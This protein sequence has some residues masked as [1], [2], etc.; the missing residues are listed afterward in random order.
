[1]IDSGRVEVNLHQRETATANSTGG[2]VH[3]RR[4]MGLTA[5]TIGGGGALRGGGRN[6][7]LKTWQKKN[8]STVSWGE[9]EIGW[10]QHDGERRGGGT[11]KCDAGRAEEEGCAVAAWEE[12]MRRGAR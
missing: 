4:V 10:R 5:S 3:R 8:G 2:G 9:K 7:T 12:E 6:L 1:L 11:G